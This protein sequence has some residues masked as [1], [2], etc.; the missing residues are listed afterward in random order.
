M[1]PAAGTQTATGT[2]GRRFPEG[3]S[4]FLALSAMQGSL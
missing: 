4:A 2:T 3:P 1:V